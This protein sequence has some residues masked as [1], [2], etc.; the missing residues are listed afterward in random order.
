MFLISKLAKSYAKYY[1]IE[2]G[3]KGKL[4]LGRLNIMLM[5]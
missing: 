5:V 2:F 1:G 4:D 3:K